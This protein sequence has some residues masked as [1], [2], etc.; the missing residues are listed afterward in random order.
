[1]HLAIVRHHIPFGAEADHAI[2][3]N[4]LHPLLDDQAKDH[5]HVELVGA[6]GQV[7]GGVARHSLCQIGGAQP[8]F[9][10]GVAQL[11]EDNQFGLLFTANL[12]DEIAHLAQ[13]GLGIGEDGR[14]LDEGN[15]D[16]TWHG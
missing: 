1:M 6:L 11:G 15:G 16:F 4:A 3:Q 2:V 7:V 5:V 9:G 8:Q 10:A 12:L 14:H 13:V